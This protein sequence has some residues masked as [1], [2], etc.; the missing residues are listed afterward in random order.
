MT[1]EIDESCASQPCHLAL[2]VSQTTCEN[3]LETILYSSRPALFTDTTGTVGR[4][5]RRT[6]SNLIV[7]HISPDLDDDARTFMAGALH[8]QVAHLGE[9]PIIHHEMY[10]G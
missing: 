9:F 10:I 1:L 5:I 2:T 4:S 8:S 6:L 3:S 7:L